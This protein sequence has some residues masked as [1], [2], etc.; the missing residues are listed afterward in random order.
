[1]ENYEKKYKNLVGKIK[2]AYMNA[3]TNSTKAVLE[4][5]FPELVESEDERIRKGLI[6][7]VSGTLKGN[8]LWHTDVTREEALAWLEKQGK[9]KPVNFAPYQIG[10]MVTAYRDNPEKRNESF[11]KPVNCMIRAYKQGIEDAISKFNLQKPAEWSEEDERMLNSCIGA[12]WATDYYSYDSRQEM[13]QWLKS[14]RP[15]K[16]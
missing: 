4:E 14:L 16:V 7:A 15:Q 2:R 12:I 8:T 3:W 9:E 1:M 5:I 11:G 10:E 13:E 6:T